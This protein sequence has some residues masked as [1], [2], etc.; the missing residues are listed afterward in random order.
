MRG[1]GGRWNLTIKARTLVSKARPPQQSTEKFFAVFL[2]TRTAW[3][4]LP[5]EQSAVTGRLAHDY[6]KAI[7]ADAGIRASLEDRS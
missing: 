6:R 3:S 7:S 4:I 1:I 5:I 2:S